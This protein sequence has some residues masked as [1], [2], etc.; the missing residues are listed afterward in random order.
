[1]TIRQLKKYLDGG[2]KLSHRVELMA[3]IFLEFATAAVDR[4]A[5]SKLKKALRRLEVLN[6][7]D[8]LT[9][10]E[11]GILA[12]TEHMDPRN[13]PE[14]IEEVWFHILPNVRTVGDLSNPEDMGLWE[15][16][17]EV[18]DEKKSYEYFAADNYH[19]AAYN[20]LQRRLSKFPPFDGNF[21][22]PEIFDKVDRGWY[23]GRF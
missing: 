1:M 17:V 2:D 6:S 19:S 18:F 4:V 3:I 23:N 21:K 16:F 22:L 20:E 12:A 15:L 7:I 8:S 14:L 13:Y 9:A 11:D 10:M 5:S